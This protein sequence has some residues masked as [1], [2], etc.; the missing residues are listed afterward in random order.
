MVR[1]LPDDG[2]RYELIDGEL[3]VTPAPRSRHQ[4]MAK[5][6]YGALD[7]YIQQH[8]IGE[9]LWPP[10]DIGLD[11]RSIVQPD[12][13]VLPP[14]L[15]RPSVEWVDVTALLL[16]IEILSPST[17]RY[18]RGVKRDYYQRH[19]V[20]EYWIVDL[21]ARLVERWRPDVE[22]PE[23]RR[24]RLA[25]RPDPAVPPLEV[26]LAALFVAALGEPER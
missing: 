24:E 5:R 19:H 3:I 20:P 11:D 25:W 17:A 21:D 18:D 14:E 6:I 26:D 1:D 7:P 22:W 10:A 16:A 4:R 15:S 23:V 12:L 2:K 8:G 13:F 9:L